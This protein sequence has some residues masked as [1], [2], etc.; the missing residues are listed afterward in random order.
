MAI[1]MSR[2]GIVVG[3]AIL[4]LSLFS[5]FIPKLEFLKPTVGFLILGVILSAFLGF[6]FIDSNFSF[7]DRQSWLGIG[8]VSAI[9]LFLLLF[10]FGVIGGDFFSASIILS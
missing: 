7:K 8:I 10:G 9:I 5:R 6:R 4:L 1:E 2:I 3:L